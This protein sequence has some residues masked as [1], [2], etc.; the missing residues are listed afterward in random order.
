LR[1]CRW[2]VAQHL[3]CTISKDTNITRSQKC[4]DARKVFRSRSCT[5]LASVYMNCCMKFSGKS[6]A[7]TIW[8]PRRRCAT[9]GAEFD[10]DGEEK[11]P[12]G[13][14]RNSARRLCPFFKADC[15]SVILP[16]ATSLVSA[17]Q[18]EIPKIGRLTG[19]GSDLLARSPYSGN[20]FFDPAVRY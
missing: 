2:A 10:P 13:T 12:I 18:L 6:I 17:S 15:S 20:I 14:L 9:V 3:S 7:V 1:R 8:P 5:G 4:W 16:S 19:R 11:R